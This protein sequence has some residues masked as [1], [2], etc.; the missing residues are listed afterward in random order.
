MVELDIKIVDKENRVLAESRGEDSTFLVYEREYEKG[1]KI[2]LSASRYDLQIVWQVDDALGEAMCCLT[3]EV[4]YEIPFGEKK[5]VYSPK[6]FSGNRHYLYA[7]IAEPDEVSRYRNLAVN[8]ADQHDV[9]GCYPHASANVETRGE[10]VFAAK[11]AID[12]VY[13]NHGHG[14]WPYTSWGINRDP[15]AEMKLEFGRVVWID[16]IRVFL[17][18]DFPHD[19]Y[20]TEATVCFSDRSREVLHLQKTDKGQIFEIQPREIEWLTFGEL[21]KAGDSSPFPALTQIEV[22]GKDK[23]SI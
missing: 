11:N 8:V 1:D 7:R 13:E 15:N 5:R 17:R 6:T 23:R 10:S 19:S 2:I 20:W 18:A 14:M 22:Y 21:L 4:A 16:C 9:R 3:G 12:G